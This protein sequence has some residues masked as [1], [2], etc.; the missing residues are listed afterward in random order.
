LALVALETY[1]LI[2]RDLIRSCRIYRLLAHFV[3]SCCTSQ[4][5]R[6]VE[7]SEGD[8]EFTFVRRKQTSIQNEELSQAL[9]VPSDDDHIMTPITEYQEHDT[10]S[11]YSDDSSRIDAP[12]IMEHQPHEYI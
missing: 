12:V 8:R 1:V 6:L 11:D 10:R 4:Y 2:N 9:I 5:R 3:C 7:E